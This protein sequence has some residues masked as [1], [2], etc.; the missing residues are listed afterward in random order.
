MVIINVWRK[1]GAGWKLSAECVEVSLNKYK[2]LIK[3]NIAECVEVS[4]NKY[5]WLIKT[6]V[7]GS[8][9]RIERIK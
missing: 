1:E 8:M 5:K 2:W 4:L 6:N 9:V 7:A 3:T